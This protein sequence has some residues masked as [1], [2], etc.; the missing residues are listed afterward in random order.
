MVRDIL[1]VLSEYLTTHNKLIETN[2][3]SSYED[4]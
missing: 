2:F 1:G 3:S 4:Q